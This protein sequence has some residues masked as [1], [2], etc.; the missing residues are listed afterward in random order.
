MSAPRAATTDL[1]A[2]RYATTL[3][4][5][6]DGECVAYLPDDTTVGVLWWAGGEVVDVEVHPAWRRRGIATAML[7]QARALDVLAHSNCRTPAGDVWARSLGAA[8][9]GDIL[10]PIVRDSPR[11]WPAADVTA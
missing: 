10:D 8:P 6:G 9:A 5:A 1:P 7:R 4:A 2:V 11:G 3:D